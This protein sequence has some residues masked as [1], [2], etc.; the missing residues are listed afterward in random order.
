MFDPFDNSRLRNNCNYG[1][2][3]SNYVLGN[4]SS[5]FSTNSL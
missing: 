1:N 5:G 3:S 2:I 4:I